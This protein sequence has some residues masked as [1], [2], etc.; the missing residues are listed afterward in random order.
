MGL[1]DNIQKEV[2]KVAENENIQKIKKEV[3]GGIDKVKEEQNKR[4]EKAQIRKEEQQLKKLQKEEEKT[5]KHDKKMNK[6]LEKQTKKNKK[7]IEKLGANGALYAI[8]ANKIEKAA[9][10]N[11]ARKVTMIFFDDRIEII[12]KGLLSGN[13]GNMTFYYDEITHIDFLK[14][15]IQKPTITIQVSSVKHEFYIK[16]SKELAE[17]VSEEIKTKAR[18]TKNQP[19]ISTPVTE[20]DKFQKL[21]DLGELKDSGII[22]DEEFEQ[23]KKKLLAE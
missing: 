4:E 5:S 19:N 2:K 12:K 16:T 20:K 9:L 10:G 7:V 17:K 22:T 13:K 8:Q 14:S 6:E 1:L 23:E 11:K 3:D 15:L 21:K 18:E